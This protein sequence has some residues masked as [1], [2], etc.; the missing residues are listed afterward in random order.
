[1]EHK[2][3]KLEFQ[4]Q[5]RMTFLEA[6]P[7]ADRQVPNDR[8]KQAIHEMS[9]ETYLYQQKMN[10]RLMVNPP[11]AGRFHVTFLKQLYT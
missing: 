1:M 10:K 6:N 2:K 11:A 8:L 9:I 7:P 3:F 4:H 5:L